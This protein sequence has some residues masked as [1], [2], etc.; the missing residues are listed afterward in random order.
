MAAV[1]LAR[2]LP[3]RGAAIR[4]A[5]GLRLLQPVA[6]GSRLSMFVRLTFFEGVDQLVADRHPGS[7]IDSGTL[8]R[9]RLDWEY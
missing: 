7:P 9:G 5:V 1:S 2:G 6:A 3:G 4:A 8:S